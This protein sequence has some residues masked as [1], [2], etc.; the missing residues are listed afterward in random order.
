[1]VL[2]RRTSRSALAAIAVCAAAALVSADDREPD[3]VARVNQALAQRG[4]AARDPQSGYL[5]PLLDALGVPPESQLLVFSKTGAQ[6][7]YTGPHTP[8]A[9]YFDTS[10]AVGYVPGAPA[11]EIAALDPQQ[12]VLFYT[13]D[14]TATA[15]ALTRRTSCLTCHVSAGTRH[16]PGLIAH[17]N[18]VGEQGQVLPKTANTDVD[19]RTPH[20]DRWGGWFVTSEFG[21]APYAQRAHFGNLT[22]TDRGV[23]SNQAFVEWLDSAPET[24]GYLSPLSDVVGLLVFDH[25]VHAIN[26][27]AKMNAEPRGTITRGLVHELAEY[28]LFVGEAPFPVAL[29]PRPEFAR[30][31]LTR[32]PKDRLG[33]SLAE[34][35][36]DQRL[37]RYPCS[38]MIYSEAFDA[39]PRGVKDAV[40]VRMREILSVTEERPGRARRTAADLRAV[41]EILADTKPDFGS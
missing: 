3:R 13:V 30:Y 25:Q 9:L 40:Y 17:S 29:T 4:A 23:T 38:Y 19:H 27:L 14:Q 11:I 35:E 15:P 1:M 7:T 32:A 16:L 6:R 24:R 2:L 36:L 18:T 41:L 20:T 34:L 8:R 26:L 31:L 5:R 39:L 37:L 12:G 22:F 10:A 28:L 21:A 33:R